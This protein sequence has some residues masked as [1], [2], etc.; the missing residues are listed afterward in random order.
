MTEAELKLLRARCH[1]LACETVLEILCREARKLDPTFPRSV[2][3][4]MD[5]WMQ[6]DI[7]QLSFPKLGPAYS[8]LYAAEGREAVT[9]L[10]QRMMAW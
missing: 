5:E 3:P 10:L 4:T 2:L 9:D 8:D 1:A 6:S 7:Q